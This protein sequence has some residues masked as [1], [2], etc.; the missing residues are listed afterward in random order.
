MLFL[1]WGGRTK[2]PHFCNLHERAHTTGSHFAQQSP[3]L[4]ETSFIPCSGIVPLQSARLQDDLHPPRLLF[5]WSS[6]I[7]YKHHSLMQLLGDFPTSQGSAPTTKLS[8][9]LLSSSGY[10]II[11]T[12]WSNSNWRKQEAPGSEYPVIITVGSTLLGHEI[13]QS[14]AENTEGSWGEK[15]YCFLLHFVNSSSE[16]MRITEF[17]IDIYLCVYVS[18]NA[19]MKC[20]NISI[21]FFFFFAFNPKP[22]E[23]MHH[24]WQITVATLKLHF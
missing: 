1:G 7:L 18:G 12:K 6:S 9:P 3:A 21:F 16:F 23:N 19:K 11:L 8:S 2:L 10:L 22:F 14:D 20:F 5:F 4:C 24:I 13:S 15:C 17:E